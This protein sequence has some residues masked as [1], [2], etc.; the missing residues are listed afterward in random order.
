MGLCEECIVVVIR[1]I[2]ESIFGSVPCSHFA[3]SNSTSF[4][5]RLVL[6]VYYNNSGLAFSSR[7]F[8]MQYSV[9]AESHCEWYSSWHYLFFPESLSEAS[10]DNSSEL[11]SHQR[12]SARSEEDSSELSAYQMPLRKSSG[13]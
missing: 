1:F 12:L 6:S 5:S 11:S 2:V 13:Q 3:L 9:T 7:F 8:V 10:L 4:N